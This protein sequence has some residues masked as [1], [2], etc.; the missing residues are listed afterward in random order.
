MANQKQ[1]NWVL[2]LT[3]PNANKPHPPQKKFIKFIDDAIDLL[4]ELLKIYKGLV[5]MKL[6]PLWIQFMK[7]ALWKSSHTLPS[8]IGDYRNHPESY[9]AQT[10]SNHS[11]L[12]DYMK[13]CTGQPTHKSKTTQVP[14]GMCPRYWAQ[15]A[16]TGGNIQEVPENMRANYIFW[17]MYAAL[18]TVDNVPSNLRN[19]DFWREFVYQK[20][21]NIP[22]VPCESQP[23]GF[24]LE[25]VME[26]LSGIVNL[27]RDLLT[28]TL[29][30]DL[31]TRLKK[32]HEV[33]LQSVAF[34]A[35]HPKFPEFEP[36]GY[37]R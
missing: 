25:Y 8:L 4:A 30:Q 32:R 33:R 23:D 36:R 1:L 14:L 16:G 31:A 18:T 34:L 22:D 37:N 19:G 9:L 27:P 24:W 13:F 20:L 28:P 17:A 35:T 2:D 12:M 7:D 3:S 11:S 21:G 15:Y 6:N 5:A 29:L 10:L 26:K